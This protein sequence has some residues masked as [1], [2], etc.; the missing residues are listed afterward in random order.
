M[1]KQERAEVTRQSIIRGAAE[2]FDRYGYSAATLGDVIGHGGV[3][4]GALYFHFKSKEDVARAVVEQQHELSVAP[5]RAWLTEEGSGLEAVIRATQLMATQLMT[6]VIVRAGIRLTLEQGTFGALRVDPYAEWTDVVKQLLQRAVD[7]GDVRSPVGAD[8]LAH[9]VC[10]AFT[11]IQILSEVFTRRQDLCRRVEEMWA[12][13]LPSLAPA[14]KVGHFRR[15][16][17]APLQKGNVPS[18]AT[19]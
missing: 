7:E 13:L 3:T 18:A 8:E 16:A 4:K 1:P 14:R 17:A 15:I 5:T 10:G 12:V 2:V 19:S 9:F 6:N 11:G